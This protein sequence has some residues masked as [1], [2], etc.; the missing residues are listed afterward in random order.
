MKVLY[1]IS[2]LGLVLLVL[3]SCFNDVKEKYNQAK[4]GI[5]NTSIIVNEAQKV[6]ARIDKLK[7]TTPLTN[8]QLKAWLPEYLESFKRQGFKVGK[9]AYANVAS[10]QGTYV[11]VHEETLGEH[12]KPEYTE[13]KFIV[14][15]TDG[16]GP[17]GGI[18]ISALQM[19]VKVDVE[20]ENDHK[21]LKSV[22]V[23]GIK[24]QET[25]FKKKNST[26]I[27]FIFKDR[28]GV[29][30]NAKNM[31]PEETWQLVKELNLKQLT[32]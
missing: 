25:Y 6:E 1:K 23:N 31:M 26:D 19:A 22:T 4:K 24:A 30:I 16:A 10:I 9:T 14:N 15:I 28:F 13:K 18:M 2:V 11:L 21:H 8:E 17:T 12:L 32:K 29:T 3:N 5:S 7:N 27:Q 20:E